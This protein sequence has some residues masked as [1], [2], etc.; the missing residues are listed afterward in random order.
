VGALG[1]RRVL[2][3]PGPLPLGEGE[4]YAVLFEMPA[5]GFTNLFIRYKALAETVLGAPAKDF[6]NNFAA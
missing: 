3:H 2:P 5:A 6:S 4:S 1:Y